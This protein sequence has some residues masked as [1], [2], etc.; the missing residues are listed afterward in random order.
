MTRTLAFLTTWETPCGIATYTENLIRGLLAN[1][2]PYDIKVFAETTGP[3]GHETETAADL[4]GKVEVERCWSRNTPDIRDLYRRLVQA[5]PDILHIQH[6]PG[7]QGPLADYEHIL[8]KLRFLGVR[9]I[10]TAHCVLK[11]THIKLGQPDGII[12][13][14]ALCAEKMPAFPQRVTTI[15]PHGVMVATREDKAEARKK[16]GIPQD[17]FV[18]VTPGHMTKNKNYSTVASAVLNIAQRSSKYANLHY[19]VHGYPQGT[20]FKDGNYWRPMKGTTQ[21]MYDKHIHPVQAYLSYEGIRT[22]LSAADAAVLI[23]GPTPPAASGSARLL[24]TF[25]VP[26]VFSKSDIFSDFPEDCALRAEASDPAHVTAQLLKLIESPDLRDSLSR[27]MLDFA[28]EN[29]WPKVGAKHLEFYERI[30]KKK[31]RQVLF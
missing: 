6:E 22:V 11:P 2:C 7:I 12:V 1:D 8:L 27:A 14:N 10:M 4:K 31:P 5:S 18:V 26:S 15:I 29:S 21:E 9:V 30:L 20:E 13:H 17:E 24:A 25:G 19:Y 3:A 23:H 16:L 28:E